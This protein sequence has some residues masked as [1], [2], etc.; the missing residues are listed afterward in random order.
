MVL[1]V[2]TEH[3]DWF[4]GAQ[5]VEALLEIAESLSAREDSERI[6]DIRERQSSQMTPH[7]MAIVLGWLETYI[8]EGKEL[9]AWLKWYQEEQASIAARQ[10]EDHR[11]SGF[12]EH[13]VPRDG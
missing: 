3:P 8:V 2:D 5:T 13:Y 12:A 6:T 10:R 9:A 11:T 1:N 7:K 4:S